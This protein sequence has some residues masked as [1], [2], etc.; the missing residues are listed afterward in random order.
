MPLRPPV[1]EA[2]HIQGNMDAPIELLQ[3]GDYQCPY[4]WKAY[5]IVKRLQSQLGEHVKF[6]FRNFPL[7][8]I[9]PHAKIAAIAS[10]AAALQGKYWEMHDLLYEKH[11]QLDR[12]AILSYAKE[13]GLDQALFEP[14]L[15][16]PELADIVETHFLSGLRSGVNATPTFFI[17]GEKY[18]E[19]WDDN[20][21]LEYIWMSNL[22]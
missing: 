22:V 12:D 16:K 9:H 17:N 4:C 8:K 14:D 6:V 15:E 13:L 2:D 1:S 7:T 11:K 5:P 20:N 19:S 10:E 21:L 18:S 3:Y